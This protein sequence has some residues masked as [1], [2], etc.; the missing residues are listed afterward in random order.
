[1]LVDGV[2]PVIQMKSIQPAVTTADDSI[3]V[4]VNFD[5]KERQ[6]NVGPK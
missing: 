5:L 4:A 1:M 6:V 3:V 2:S